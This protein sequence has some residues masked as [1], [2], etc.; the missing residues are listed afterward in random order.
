MGYVITYV[1]RNTRGVKHDATEEP[2][3][4]AEAVALIEQLLSWTAKPTQLETI[5]ITVKVT[6]NETH[7]HR[8]GD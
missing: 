3:T 6:A 8:R 1:W 2:E 4:K 7:D 5:I